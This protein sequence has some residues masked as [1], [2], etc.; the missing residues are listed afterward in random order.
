[1]KIKQR[2]SNQ[3]NMIS[4]FKSTSIFSLAL[5]IIET[6]LLL[7]LLLLLFLMQDQNNINILLPRRQ[8][9]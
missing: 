5:K 4:V 8:Q 9:V 1:M 7:L 6:T 3:V 2:E